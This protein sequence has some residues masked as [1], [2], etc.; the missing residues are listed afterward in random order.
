[1][2]M[3]ELKTRSKV[4]YEEHG[5]E[6]AFFFIMGVLAEVQ[7][8]IPMDALNSAEHEIK[9]ISSNQLLHIFRTQSAETWLTQAEIAGLIKIN[10]NCKI[11]YT[12]LNKQLQ[13]LVDKKI[14][15]VKKVGRSNQYHI[16]M[17]HYGKFRYQ[18]GRPNH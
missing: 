9:R 4:I 16:Y 11:L 10:Y 7:P 8:P 2:D 6:A 18:T 13:V 3:Y 12:T 17:Q 5:M 14:I 1:M 15:E